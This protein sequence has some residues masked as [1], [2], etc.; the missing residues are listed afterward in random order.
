MAK[1][2]PLDNLDVFCEFGDA[3]ATALYPW[4]AER[5]GGVDEGV[6]LC[7]P[8]IVETVA[9]LEL[10]VKK[11]LHVAFAVVDDAFFEEPLFLDVSV[12]QCV[13]ERDLRMVVEQKGVLAAQTVG[14]RLDDAV[15]AGEGGGV[16]VLQASKGGAIV[17]IGA[18]LATCRHRHDG[19]KRQE[20][21]EVFTIHRHRC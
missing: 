16:L 15:A 12:V 18:T 17:R 1:G 13:D 8:R 19:G 2:M 20:E 4:G 9:A 10:F 3:L 14:A 7:G 21:G 11:K 6:V 5:L